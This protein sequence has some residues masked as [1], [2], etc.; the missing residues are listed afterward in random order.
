[1]RRKIIYIKYGELTLKG[2]NRVSFINSLYRTIKKALGSFE[3]IIIKKE[4]DNTVIECDENNVSSILI[5][6]KRVPGIQQIIKAHKID[7]NSFDIIGTE[8]V[9]ILKGHITHN[10][11]TFKVITK[12]HD[13]KY[14]IGSMEFSKKMG[15]VVLRSFSSLT[16]KMNNYDLEINI[17][18]K[19]DH[20]I[21]FFEREKGFGGFPIGI[22]GKVIMLISGGID[23]PVAAALL[24]KKGV[25]VDFLTFLTPPHTS[26]ELLTKVK[27]LIGK[28]S[29]DNKLYKPILYTVNFS[30]IQ[31]ELAHIDLESYQI[32]LM[33]RYFFKIANHIAKE[34]KYL[35]ISTGE[36]L[37]QV[38]SQTLESMRAISQVLDDDMLILRPL[39]S[40]DKIEIISIAKE[41]DTYETSIL[42]YPDCCSLFVPNAPV[43]KPKIK[44]AK[45]LEEK[46]DLINDIFLNTLNKYIK[47]ED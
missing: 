32:T 15:G 34:N 30:P 11:K 28:L 44:T 46:L 23:S 21:I 41:I 4:F 25:H 9:E 26:D 40:L 39:L 33:R 24:L 38:A 42:P 27:T 18:I 22:N 10:H 19:K 14:E 29:L 20:T 5:I 7:S 37:G 12:R 47:I 17:E 3:N 13:K 36:S 8:L 16:V 2:K 6:L 45:W 31:H 1:M 35:A 43:T